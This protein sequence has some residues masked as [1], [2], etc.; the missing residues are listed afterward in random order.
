MKDETKVTQLDLDDD[1]LDEVRGG[2]G[3]LVCACAAHD[4]ACI[5]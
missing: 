2:S 3:A 4:A 1:A 5:D